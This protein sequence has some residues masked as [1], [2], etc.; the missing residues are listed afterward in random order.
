MFDGIIRTPI[1]KTAA[2]VT[3]N[4]NCCDDDLE[5][6]AQQV[7]ERIVLL[8]EKRKELSNKLGIITKAQHSNFMYRANKFKDY[9]DNHPQKELFAEWI[10][11]GKEARR[12]NQYLAERRKLRREALDEFNK[13]QIRVLGDRYPHPNDKIRYGMDV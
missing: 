8:V 1:N 5:M 6:T 13:H 3:I 2:L 11:V 10:R 4:T 9:V 7:H 12:L